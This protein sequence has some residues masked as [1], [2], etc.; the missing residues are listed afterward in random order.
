[1]SPKTIDLSP[2]RKA[3][4]LLQEALQFWQAQAEG[5]A[6]KPHLRSAVIQSFEFT[7]ELAVR[8][9]RRVLIERAEAADLGPVN[10]ISRE[11]VADQKGH[12]QG[13][14]RSRGRAPAMFRNAAHGLF[15]H[16]PKGTG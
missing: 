4:A 11:R 6:L 8:L 7:Y 10:A 12:A 15:D 5:S 2:L 9:L 16:N 3:L 13:A 1:M 14:K